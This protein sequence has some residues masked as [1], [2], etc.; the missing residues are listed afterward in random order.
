MACSAMHPDFHS[1]VSLSPEGLAIALALAKGDY[2]WQAVHYMAPQIHITTSKAHA[3]HTWMCSYAFHE[4]TRSFTVPVVKSWH[5]NIIIYYLLYFLNTII[6]YNLRRISQGSPGW[7]QAITSS[8]FSLSNAGTIGL[9]HHRAVFLRSHKHHSDP[10]S[11][12]SLK[13][14]FFENYLTAYLP[15]P[16]GCHYSFKR[17]RYMERKS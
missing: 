3:C 4:D 16:A 17:H 13:I 2:A 6:Q 8:C 5:F 11:L 10:C 14:T 15:R 7:S 9:F 12:L 1:S